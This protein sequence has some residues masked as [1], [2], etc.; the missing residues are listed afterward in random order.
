MTKN[1]AR[2]DDTKMADYKTH[3]ETS[4]V[5]A[6]LRVPIKIHDETKLYQTTTKFRNR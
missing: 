3:T 1:K 5:I 6:Q 2:Y 4:G